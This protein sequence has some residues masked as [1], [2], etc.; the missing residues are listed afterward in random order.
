MGS[1]TAREVIVMNHRY[2]QLFR[3]LIPSWRFFGG[4]SE[5]SI[6]FY[7]VAVEGGEL[8]AWRNALT[9]PPRKWY[10]LF[11]NAEGNL[12]LA[13]YALLDQLEDDLSR[14]AA[15]DSETCTELVSF[16]LTRNLVYF[17]LRERGELRNGYRY[18][19]KISRLLVDGSP[20]S[21]EDC[22]FS[23]IYKD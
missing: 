21:F 7:R 13:C 20:S 1:L 3:I 5:Q 14:I 23:P 18:Q 9:R 10:S 4:L 22:F 11:L 12:F 17:L 19:F 2:L 6:L 15:A 8:G 16:Q